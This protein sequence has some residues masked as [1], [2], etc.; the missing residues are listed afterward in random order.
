L[1]A[2]TTFGGNLRDSRQT[3]LQDFARGLSNANLSL[4]G[5]ANYGVT[6]TGSRS[7]TLGGY[8]EE[9]LQVAERVFLTGALRVDAASGFGQSYQATTYPK[10]SASWLALQNGLTSVRLR[11]AFGAS[12]VAPYNGLALQLYTPTIVATSTGGNASAVQ[13]Q[14]P[15][16][17]QLKPERTAEWEGGADLSFFGNRLGLELT[18]YTKT[19]QDALY[20]E[21]LGWDVNSYPYEVNIG[22]ISNSGAE[23]QVTAVP[24]LSRALAWTVTM[25]ASVNHNKLIHLAPGLTPL[26]FGSS[27]DTRIVPGFP[28]YGFWGEPVRY[29]DANHDGILEPNEVTIDTTPVY[30]GSS[31]PTQQG[32]LDSHISFFGGALAIGSLFT[33]QGGYRVFNSFALGAA[34]LGSLPEQNIK[35]APLWEQ[36]RAVAIN[37]PL[38]AVG[39]PTGFFEDG[40]VW[41]FQELSLTWVLPSRFARVARVHNLSLT[42]AVRNLA[43]W[44]RYS[45][46][47]P[48]SSN[49]GASVVAPTTGYATVNNDVRESG[50]SAVPL[51]RYYQLRLNVG[52]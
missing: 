44:T 8:A 11:G 33:Y 32:A 20:D 23:A 30:V 31:L 42:G 27:N 38:A 39:S 12:G 35:G 2:V 1:R 40:T 9:Q 28:L 41:R 18:G 19:T 17:P 10:V 14:Q 52:F 43:Y 46:G 37:S 3:S 29:S 50:A 47:D 16:N 13:L 26:A 15:G 36:A 24:V 45:S 25:S 34:F 22:E 6:Q 21:T 49:P 5:A 51:A 4:L 7:A 48:G